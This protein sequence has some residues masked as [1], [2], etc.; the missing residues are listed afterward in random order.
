MRYILKIRNINYPTDNSNIYLNILF[1]FFLY[2]SFNF[3]EIFWKIH[4]FIKSTCFK[5]LHFSPFHS[6][7]IGNILTPISRAL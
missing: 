3:I 6:T 5:K 4:F 2:K 1:V 7:Q